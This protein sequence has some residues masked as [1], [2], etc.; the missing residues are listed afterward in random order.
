MEKFDYINILLSFYKN[1]LT[2]RQREILEYYYYEDLSLTE[3]SDNL[4]ISRNA[5]F[6][7]IKKGENSLKNY[8][9]KMHL[10]DDYK[11]RVEFYDELKK[12]GNDQVDKIVDELM[13]VEEQNYE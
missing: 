7:A 3:I 6:D 13:K 2:E 1:L 8:E 4:N 9:E 10:Y 11:K 5:V 12:L